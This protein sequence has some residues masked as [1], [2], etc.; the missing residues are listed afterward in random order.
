MRPGSEVQDIARYALSKIKPV[1]TG[2]HIQE[3]KITPKAAALELLDV[4]TKTE[5]QRRAAERYKRTQARL[6]AHPQRKHRQQ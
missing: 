6:A 4:L 3:G 2:M 5:K 1:D